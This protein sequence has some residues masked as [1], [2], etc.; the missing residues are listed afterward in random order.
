MAGLRLHPDAPSV[1]LDDFL[2]DRE[3]DAG[4]W[5]FRRSVQALKDHEDPFGMLRVDSDAVISHGKAPLAIHFLRRN[6]DARRGRAVKLE[7]VADQVLNELEQ[8][9]LVGP[10][11]R[12]RIMGDNSA[13]FL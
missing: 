10:H 11:R 9:S 5:V 8:L 2:C 13:R 6:V 3:A 12:Q 7:S 4:A 1:P